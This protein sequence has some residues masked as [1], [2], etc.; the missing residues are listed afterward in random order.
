MATPEEVDLRRW[1]DEFLRRANGTFG[2]YLI[3]GVFHLFAWAIP[4]IQT[5]SGVVREIWKRG[6]SFDTDWIPISNLLTYSIMNGIGFAYVQIITRNRRSGFYSQN[7]NR[8][9]FFILIM[10]VSP[11]VFYSSTLVTWCS[12][13]AIDRLVCAEDDL[14][15]CHSYEDWEVFKFNYLWWTTWFFI[16]L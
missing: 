7:M 3:A 11:F 2:F 1:Y 4:D 12:R 13:H 10:V 8:W 5:D 6:D 9:D 15:E 16:G 14:A